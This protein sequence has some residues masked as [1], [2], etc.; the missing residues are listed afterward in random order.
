[1]ANRA[2]LLIAVETFFEVGPAV[3]YA[4][5]D[6]A[7]L[8]RLLPTVGYQPEKCILVAGTRTTKASI[9]SHLRRLPKLIDKA[10][11]LLV[12]IVTRGFSRNNR[13]YLACA[14]TLRPDPTE[15]SL[16]IADLIA[17][18]HKTKCKEITLLLDV[19]SLTFPG[20]T[21]PLGLHEGELTKLFDASSTC[22]GLLSCEPG[23]RS[24]ESAALRHGIWRHQLIEV[25]SGKV[26]AKLSAD[27]T[28]TAGTLHEFLADAVP[29]TVRRTYDTP[30][31]QT[32]LLFGDT[33]AEFV[34]ADLGTLLGPGSEL[35]DPTRMKRVA[36]RAEN[37][38]NIKNLAGYRKTHSL[39]DR[40]NEWARKYIAR[41]AA[42]DIKADLDNTFDRVR[43][44]FG[45]KR[46][47]LDVSAER[48]GMGYIRTPDFEYTITVNVNPDDLSEVI[49]Q[50][51]I[52]RL[53]GPEFVRTDGFKHVFGGVFDRLVFEFAQ[54]VDVADFVDRIE[55][56]PPEGVKIIVASDA[57]EAE[58]KLAGFAGKVRLTP[59]SVVIQGRSG[60]S[61]GLLEQF[62]AFLRKFSGLGEPKALPPAS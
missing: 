41:I 58:V 4:A 21:E 59:D 10:D 8:H 16:T 24:F 48:D 42:P 37:I 5:A 43:E 13:G 36:F 44:S 45:Y 31:E 22:V 12:C 34:V 20:E 39:P 57:N 14:D 54:P 35:L 53:S 38:A 50:R 23:A 28:L 26:R 51:E 40:A 33:N 32:P 11:S 46:K 56:D 61:A 29:R 7:E 17:T 47:D 6:C 49:W 30:E 3:P 25:L 18:L 62:L 60:D 1:M 15:T 2:A 9:E 52:G 19:D 55:D 27:N